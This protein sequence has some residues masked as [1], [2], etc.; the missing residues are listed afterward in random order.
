MQWRETGGNVRN[1]DVDRRHSVSYC[2]RMDPWWEQTNA[3][4]LAPTS[5]DWIRLARTLRQPPPL[6]QQ[7]A[8]VNAL[9]RESAAVQ[10]WETTEEL[11]AR[12]RRLRDESRKLHEEYARLMK[13]IANPRR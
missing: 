3:N 6:P 7:H 13:L 12:A 2:A 4:A 8:A 11:L 1:F 10:R 9:A 5:G